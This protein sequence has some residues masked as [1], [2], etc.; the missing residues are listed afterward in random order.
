MEGITQIRL[1][2]RDYAK[3]HVTLCSVLSMPVIIR[4]GVRSVAP[5][6]YYG[7]YLKVVGEPVYF[8]FLIRSSWAWVG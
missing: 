3:L 6:V 2:L 1:S 5:D 4:A 7:H 8:L